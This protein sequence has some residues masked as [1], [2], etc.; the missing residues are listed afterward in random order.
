VGHD[1]FEIKGPF[2]RGHIPDILHIKYLRKDSQRQSYGYEVAAKTNLWLR[3]TTT[4]GSILKGLGIR[5]V[6]NH[7]SRGRG[8]DKSVIKYLSVLSQVWWLIPVCFGGRGRR[9]KM[10]SSSSSS[11]IQLSS[12]FDTNVDYKGYLISKT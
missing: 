6:E 2:R 7:C 5:R 4:W 8:K 12:K 9:I 10:S 3:V 1:P 11:A